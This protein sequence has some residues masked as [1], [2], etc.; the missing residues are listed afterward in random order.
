M[1]QSD[2]LIILCNVWL[3]SIA[4][5]TLKEQETQ[6]KVDPEDK[7][8]VVFFTNETRYRV[9]FTQVTQAKMYYEQVIQG[10]L[11]V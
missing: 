3:Q 1:Q 2:V 11:N 9:R 5:K 6:I 10:I 8:V 4:F 7:Y